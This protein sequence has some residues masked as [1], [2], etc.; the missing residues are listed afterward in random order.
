MKI[1]PEQIE[2]ALR[3]ADELKK[4]LSKCAERIPIRACDAVFILSAAYREAMAEIERL[5][6]QIENIELE[7]AEIAEM[8]DYAD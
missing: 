1:T 2:A 4:P 8:R 5:N 7:A 3:Y 6:N